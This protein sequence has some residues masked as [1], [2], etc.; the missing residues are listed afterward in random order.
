MP[1][2]RETPNSGCHAKSTPRQ[3]RLSNIESLLRKRCCPEVPDSLLRLL[4]RPS[5]LLV[6][7]A[8]QF[9]SQKLCYSHLQR[10]TKAL[11]TMASKRHSVEPI[12]V[13]DTGPI[14]DA[15]TTRRRRS[16]PD[17]GQCV[18]DLDQYEPL[19][20]KQR[21]YEA[22]PFSFPTAAGHGYGSLPIHH[23]GHGQPYASQVLS[24]LEA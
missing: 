22:K 7:S 17:I 3:S 5:D 12:A 15:T 4:D 2:Y 20:K 18:S 9:D 10:F 14:T 13:Q 8:E 16:L 6:G 11:L 19:Q 21:L 1:S 23:R 24:E